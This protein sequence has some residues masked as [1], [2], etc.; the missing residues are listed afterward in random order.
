MQYLIP[1][2]IQDAQ[3]RE[4]L[5]LG[6][7][8]DD[9]LAQTRK[10]GLVTFYSRSKKRL[11]QKGETSGNT[12][13]VE[14][15]YQDCDNDTYL[16][17]ATPQGPTCHNGTQSCFNTQQFGLPELTK[18]INQRKS[19]MPP[20][21][22][23]TSLFRAGLPQ[24]CAKITEESQEVVQAATQETK[25]RLIEES[26]D[27]LYH[28]QVLLTEKGITQAEIDQELQKRNQRT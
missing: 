1:T 22:Y 14:K 16:I 21:S 5:M 3:T 28:L 23:T 18:L 25:Q 24:I 6:Y 4:V 20:D 8:N 13:K 11:W 15:I 2:I 27:L 10:T 19:T 26:C 12:L 17:L 7:M 9:A